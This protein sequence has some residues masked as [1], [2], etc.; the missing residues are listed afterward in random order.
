MTILMHFALQ[1]Y[2]QDLHVS[3]IRR[4]LDFFETR[5]ALSVLF[6]FIQL[7]LPSHFLK[8]GLNVLYSCYQR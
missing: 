2:R 4:G 3:H 7:C 6:A 8:T 1:Q 5:I